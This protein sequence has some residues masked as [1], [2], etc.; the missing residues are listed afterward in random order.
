MFKMEFEEIPLFCTHCWW[1]TEFASSN[2][3][4]PICFR[5]RVWVE[6]CIILRHCQLDKILFINAQLSCG[7]EWQYP[8]YLPFRTRKHSVN[9]LCLT[10]ENYSVFATSSTCVYCTFEDVDYTNWVRRWIQ[11]RLKMA[12]SKL[13][14]CSLSQNQ[15]ENDIYR[16]R[17]VGRDEEQKVCVDWIKCM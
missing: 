8:P 12:W 13:M 2:R 5:A 4:D 11:I 14:P 3:V 9:S 7:L 17:I 1:T 15:F 10:M 6:F 16:E